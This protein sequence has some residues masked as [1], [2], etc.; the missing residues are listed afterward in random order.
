MLRAETDS[1]KNIIVA[2]FGN[3]RITLEE[4][5]IGYLDVLKNPK[6]IDS[7]DLRA[8]FLDEMIT[9]RV[10][11]QE[12]E[13]A[14]KGNDEA[15]RYKV[16]AFHDKCLRNQHFETV[17]RPK[18]HIEENDVEE[19]YLF[20]QEKRK[21]R[22]L[23]FKEKSAAD[24]ALALLQ[25]GVSF[26]SLARRV[27]TDTAM[28]NS[29][30]DLGWVEWDQLEY[31]MGSTA[32]HLP[33]GVY[34]R[35]VKSQFGFH[36]LEVTNFQKNPLITQQQYLEHRKKAR[37]L[38]E[39][40]LGDKYALEHIGEMLR[41]A[42]ITLNPDV[43]EFVQKKLQ[44]VFKR[45]PALG[46]QLSEFQLRDDEVRFVERTLWDSRHDVIA[47]VNGKQLT[48]GEFVAG[49]TFIP[50]G[51]VHNSFRRALEY[52]LRDFLITKEAEKLGLARS[53]DVQVRTSLYR[54]YLLQFDSR[55]KIV[56]SVRVSQKEIEAY[57]R[58]NQKTFREATLEQVR[59]FIKDLILTHKK[60]KAVPRHVAKLTKGIT[61]NKNLK[62][63]NDYY[64]GILNGG[65]K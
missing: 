3:Q 54:E 5:R 62:A 6:T 63:I 28:A 42:S 1:T 14:G 27:F 59:D 8:G 20:T 17:I 13:K 51:I 58:E 55:L 61:I 37:Y 48:V 45:S 57:Y 46:D 10:L 40:K 7:R 26:E 21:I 16:K 33:V 15:L 52:G 32:F 36:I 9:G 47:L 34:S 60:Q 41:N 24:S 12:A 56:G 11:A 64:D 38:L 53:H 44:N 43:V 39:Y 22:H 49:L 23:F 50:Y 35:P 65:A 2:Q 31:D 19:A 30:G 25:Q 4:F 29:G 18:F